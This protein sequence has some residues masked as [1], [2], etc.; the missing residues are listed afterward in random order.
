MNNTADVIIIG[1]G[2][3]GNSAAYYCVQKGLKVIV[4]E[5]EMIGNGGSSR[6][7]GGVRVSGRDLRE[8]PLALYATKNIW[9]TLSEE[10]G[11]DVEYQRNGY[12]VCGYNDEHKK[13]IKER[14]VDAAKMGIEM[15]FLEG[16]AIK[17]KCKYVSEHVTCAGWTP[18]DGTANPLVTTLGFYKRAKELGARFITGEKVVKINLIKG[19]ARQVVTECGN[20]YEGGRIV[21]AAGYN[22]RKLLNTIGLDV[23]VRKR[24]IE[25]IV[26][27]PMPPMFNHMIGGMSG[28]Y[29]H[30]TEH[31]S[32][33]F[34]DN[35][36]RENFMTDLPRELSTVSYTST[37]CS[38]IGIDIPKLKEAKIIRS[39]AGITD[40]CADG[41][42]ILGNV[43]EV[44]DLIV[45]AGCSA[46]GFCPGPATGYTIAQ[47]ANDEDLDVDI[48]ALAYERFDI[49]KK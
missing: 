37:I 42:P 12:F 9:P 32:F 47:L 10:L 44:P 30:Q 8:M 20:V 11:V 31:G 45:S 17:E 16:D 35:S 1:A 3:G 7:G 34:G 49:G 19:H 22:G 27:E 48:S 15:E 25:V 33:V 24:L 29:G 14:I 39:W 43:K 5:E 2:I 4:L 38:H 21:V 26:T 18:S 40:M 6:N 28:F 13:E 23:P 36:G 46:H 41:V